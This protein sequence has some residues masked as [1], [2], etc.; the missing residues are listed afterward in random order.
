MLSTALSA[1]LLAASVEEAGG[2]GGGLADINLCLTIWTI[3]L[4][5][6]FA[7]VL[8]KV[9]WKPLFLLGNVAASKGLVFKPVG[10][11]SAKGSISNTYLKD[12][13][14]AQ[15]TNDAGMKEYKANLK[16][17]APRLNPDEP[18]N[19][20]GWAVAET[21]TKALEQAGKDL[22]REKLM[23]AVRNMDQEI[24]L[25]LPGIRIKTSKDDGYPIQSVQIERFDGKDWKVQGG[26]FDSNET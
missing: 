26:I 24:S 17:Y 14:S 13:E 12:P 4:F 9:G 11:E 18:F 8:T 25:L 19:V 23:D 16:K 7:F 10:L 15:Y 3:V 22:T 6:L 1:A 20:Y 2:G 5:A 21:M